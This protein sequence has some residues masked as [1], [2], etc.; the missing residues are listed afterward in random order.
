[1]L[2]PCDRLPLE[3]PQDIDRKMA[4][5]YKHKTRSDVVYLEEESEM[6]SQIEMEPCQIQK[7]AE[8]VKDDIDN[9]TKMKS[10]LDDLDETHPYDEDDAGTID[11]GSDLDESTDSDDRKTPPIFTY[12]LYLP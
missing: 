11:P 2:L 5:K 1:M 3:I 7:L 6:N 9:Y 4:S 12:N 10:R 8:I